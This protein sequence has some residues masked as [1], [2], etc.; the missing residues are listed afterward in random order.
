MDPSYDTTSVLTV[1]SLLAVL[2]TAILL[3]GFCTGSCCC[4]ARITCTKRDVAAEASTPPPAEQSTPLLAPLHEG[5]AL[6]RRRDS[7]P[8]RHG[9]NH[10]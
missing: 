9:P 7:T 5:P 4:L 3:C 6:P 1:A 8:R 10:R 2:I